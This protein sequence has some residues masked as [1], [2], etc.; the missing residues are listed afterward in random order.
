MKSKRGVRLARPPRRQDETDDLG[1]PAASDPG[2]FALAFVAMT[3]EREFPA[4]RPLGRRRGEDADDLGLPSESDPADLA[5]AF[6]AVRDLR[7]IARR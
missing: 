4:R 5:C 3:R 7:S 1:L 6:V 2:G